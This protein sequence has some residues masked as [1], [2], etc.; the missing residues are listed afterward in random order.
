MSIHAKDAGEGIG[1]DRAA[2]AR[3]H[4]RYKLSAVVAFAQKGPSF[5]GVQQ[6]A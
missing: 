4:P 5:L 1:W 6:A 2:M 3:F